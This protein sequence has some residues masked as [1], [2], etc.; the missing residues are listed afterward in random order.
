[1]N[2]Q[3]NNGSLYKDIKTSVGLSYVQLLSFIENYK[4]IPF[5]IISTFVAFVIY[6]ASLAYTNTSPSINIY[7]NKMFY[8]LILIIIPT[9]VVFMYIIKL[10]IGQDLFQPLVIFSMVVAAGLLVLFVLIYGGL[11]QYVFNTYSLYLLTVA[12]FIV[13]LSIVYNIFSGNL[14][15]TS[16]WLGFFINLVFYIPCLVSD[17]A[18]YLLNDIKATQSSVFVLFIFEILLI[19]AYMFVLP[20][21]NS[22]LTGGGIS[23]IDKPLFISSQTD[24]GTDF[25]TKFKNKRHPPKTVDVISVEATRPEDS[26]YS[27]NYALSMW[28]YLN[29]MPLSRLSYSNETTIFNYSDVDGNG[30]PKLTYVN[31]SEGIDKY[32]LY[33]SSI[34]VYSIELPHQKWNNFVFNY[35]DNSVDVFVNG[36]LERTFIFS[37]NDFP[38]YSDTDTIT[39][40]DGTIELKGLYGS[41]CNV[42]YYPKPIS[43]STIVTNY[44]LLSIHNPPLSVI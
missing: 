4:L 37:G 33:F 11:S 38:K 31:N 9:I 5:I 25:I 20:R 13:G 34:A 16:G 14:K 27:N 39:I 36:N 18:A 10:T 28:V 43:K 26:P 8:Y 44:N 7:S 21:A 24:I 17:F 40:G 19:L 3:P 29:P 35:H 23:L 6:I 41:I 30:H 15:R 1:M 22:F 2:I 12:I 32:N 42:V